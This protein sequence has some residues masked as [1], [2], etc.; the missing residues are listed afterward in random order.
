MT[1]HEL[2]PDSARVA[3]SIVVNVEEGSEMTVADGDKKPEPVDELG[4]GLSIPI[5]N[6][7][8]E[9]NY[10]YGI[11][12]GGPRVLDLLAKHEITA[13]FTAAALSLER[14]PELTERIVAQGHEICAHGWRWIHQFSFDEERERDFIRKAANSIERSTGTRPQGWLSRYLHTDRT[15]RLL[16]EEGYSYH[17][18]DLSDDMPRWEAVDM[19][20]GTTKSLLCIP[21]AI[22]TND[23]KFWTSPAYTP[24]QWLAYISNSLDWLL[25]EAE[26]H[27]PRMLSVGVHLRIIGRPGRIGALAKFLEYATAKPG[28]WITT[29][30]EIGA[31]Y[32]AHNAKPE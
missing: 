5:R 15:R 26:E 17:M 20:D 1:Q 32:T 21:Y 31:R 3:L 9:S 25:T 12:A 4:V 22:D 19:A 8:N 10:Q 16:I 14:A 29:R 24:D 6:Y 23:M 11:R 30:A 27:G 7:V 28:V 13:T 18:D 2:W